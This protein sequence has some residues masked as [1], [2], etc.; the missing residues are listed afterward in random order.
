MKGSNISAVN[1][2]YMVDGVTPSF[3]S[4]DFGLVRSYKHSS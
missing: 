4:H 2:K 1:I 3:V